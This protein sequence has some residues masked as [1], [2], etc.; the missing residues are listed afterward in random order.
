[1]TD[2]LLTVAEVADHFKV[3]TST[4]LAELSF[5]SGM[6]TG[7]SGNLGF[8]LPANWAFDQ[9]LEYELGSGDGWLDL[10]KDIASG[11][12]PGQNAVDHVDLLAQTLDFIDTV[13][14]LAGEFKRSGFT[15][16]QTAVE[17]AVRWLR[18]HNSAYRG[19]VHGTGW[20][21]LGG[22]GSSEFTTWMEQQR[23]A[24]RLPFSAAFGTRNDNF[25]PV[26][27][28]D[29]PHLMDCLSAYQFRGPSRDQ[30]APEFSDAAGWAGDM[31]TLLTGYMADRRNGVTS[32]DAKTWAKAALADSGS[33]FSGVD[34]AA[35]A[36]AWLVA[37]QLANGAGLTSSIRAQVSAMPVPG[38]VISVFG[39][40]RWSS[41][42]AATACARAVFDT[43]AKSAGFE[44]YRTAL[45]AVVDPAIVL[46]DSNR[47]HGY[48]IAEAVAERLTM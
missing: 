33:S 34:I 11:R 21:V 35:D 29:W 1:M 48:S 30:T 43:P 18:E 36:L 15:G 2:A 25:I 5:V 40:R 4:G 13:E 14:R 3:S 17:L 32:A 19:E 37:E 6:S 39:R 38:G 10:D 23:S 24:G 12:D 8:P 26:G 41:R 28:Y 45:L 7:Y 42:A 44:S 9:I 46:D 27:G 16:T 47:A 31:V 20:T 22:L